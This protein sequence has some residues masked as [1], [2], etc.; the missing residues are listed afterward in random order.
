MRERK[1]IT[2]TS[3]GNWFFFW[4]FFLEFGMVNLVTEGKSL[5]GKKTNFL[6]FWG[7]YWGGFLEMI[8]FTQGTLML[9][10]GL[11][12]LKLFSLC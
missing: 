8:Q 10:M 2:F 5:G 6:R 9:G 12:G 7:S 1:R 11:M 3:A 4:L